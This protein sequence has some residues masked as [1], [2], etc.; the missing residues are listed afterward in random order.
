LIHPCYTFEGHRAI[1]QIRPRKGEFALQKDIQ[2]QGMTNGVEKK[3]AGK[4]TKTRSEGSFK[5]TKG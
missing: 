2:K 1:F 3:L 5:K 4:K